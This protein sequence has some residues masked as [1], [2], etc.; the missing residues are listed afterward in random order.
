MQSRDPLRD[1][2]TIDR[3]FA[4]KQACRNLKYST[5]RPG[6]SIPGPAGMLSK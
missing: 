2:T 1:R 5:R 4:R 6:T 3:K